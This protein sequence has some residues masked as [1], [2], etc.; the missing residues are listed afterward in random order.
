[1]S[2][3]IP[4]VPYQREA[5]EAALRRFTDRVLGATIGANRQRVIDTFHDRMPGR[6]RL[7][8]RHILLDGDRVA[9]TLGYMPTEFLVDGK[10]VEGRYT[11][12]LLVD[13]DYR[14]G[15][16]G[17]VIVAHACQQGD[18]F[19]GGMWMTGQCHRIHQQMGFD[20]VAELTTYTAVL[21]TA[22]F[23]SRRSYPLVKGAVMRAGL[24]V[25]RMLA[26]RR[27]RAALSGA[28][29]ALTVTKDMDPAHDNAW[30]DLAKS[31]S[32]TRVRDAAY[33]NWKYGG[34]PILDYRTVIATRDGAPRGFLVWRPAPAGAT[35]RRAV[36]ADF[37]VRKGDVQTLQELVSKALVDAS[38][39][40]I[41][42]VAVIATQS[43]AT[44][45]VRRLGFVASG[46]HN[47][48]VVANWQDV[49]PRE[50]LTD[51]DRWHMCM[52]DSDGDM[53][54]GSM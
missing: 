3:E 50:W 6:E 42:A 51:L 48:W 31:Y 7:P 30:L 24:T 5:H 20:D 40:G 15:G 28:H 39:M 23:V 2:K 29:N 17:K 13:P 19:P 41:D 26:L 52:G 37:L 49:F 16:L 11:H 1:L 36:I 33:L 4:V 35:E 10:R 43:F 53:W 12:D 34:H 54:T 46:S 8:L 45:V 38:A 27:A 25:T 32:V 21:D 22:S 44:A 14:G 47:A 9:G 18:F